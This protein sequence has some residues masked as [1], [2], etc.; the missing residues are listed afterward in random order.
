LRERIVAKPLIYFKESEESEESSV[1]CQLLFTVITIN[2]ESLSSFD[3]KISFLHIS[4]S[5]LAT[6]HPSH[7]C[8]RMNSRETT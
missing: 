5:H 8:T 7:L 2:T 1:R 6:V 4:L 3:T